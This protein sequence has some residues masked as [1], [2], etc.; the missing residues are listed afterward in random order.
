MPAFFFYTSRCRCR[1][2][3]R[4]RSHPRATTAKALRCR[5]RRICFSSASVPALRQRGAG[6]S[7]CPL[8]I[9]SYSYPSRR[10]KKFSRAE[11]CPRNSFPL[12]STIPTRPYSSGLAI[13]FGMVRPFGAIRCNS[14][15]LLIP[16]PVASG[17]ESGPP[18]TGIWHS[19]HIS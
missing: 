18:G 8:S 2:R 6:R 11:K 17:P 3:P 10:G 5:N 14:A 4:N 1:N 19:E 9:P 13:A 12:F 16:L 15:I 7:F